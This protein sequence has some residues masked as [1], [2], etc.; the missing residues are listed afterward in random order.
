MAKE[1]PTW[2]M[3][4]AAKP[5]KAARLTLR[6]GDMLPVQEKQSIRG[7]GVAYGVEDAWTMEWA[8]LPFVRTL[9]VRSE[10]VA[11]QIREQGLGYREAAKLIGVE[12]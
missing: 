12:A 3:Y 9:N 11:R 8:K 10:Q 2:P 7:L 4:F 1:F 6:E 5:L